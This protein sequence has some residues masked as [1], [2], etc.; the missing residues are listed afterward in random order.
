PQ[1]VGAGIALEGVHIDHVADAGSRKSDAVQVVRDLIHI[2]GI[3]ARVRDINAVLMVTRDG[4]VHDVAAYAA[5]YD[6][7]VAI[8]ADVRAGDHGPGAIMHEDALIG[9][10]N[11]ERLYDDII[12][13][14]V[15]ARSLVRIDQWQPLA[16]VAADQGQRLTDE[17]VLMICAA[18][19]GDRIAGAR[20]GD[21][22]ADSG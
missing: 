11:A 18:I 1:A 8:I 19:H 6:D 9:I 16:G 7:A 15:D 5:R 12:G 10:D 14:Y 21:R 17:Q 3:A 4:I 13:G 22:R 2:H 20:V